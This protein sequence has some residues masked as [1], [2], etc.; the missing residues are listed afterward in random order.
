[1]CPYRL[2]LTRQNRRVFRLNGENV[3][4][5][6]ETFEFSGKTLFANGKEGD[7]WKSVIT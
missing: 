3:S 6:G 1:M 2:I 4:T 5:N 7:A